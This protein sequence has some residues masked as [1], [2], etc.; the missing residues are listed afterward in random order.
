MARQPTI[1]KQLHKNVSLHE[2][3]RGIRHP[4]VE[5]WWAV[6]TTGIIDCISWQATKKPAKFGEQAFEWIFSSDADGLGSFETLCEL[7]NINPDDIRDKIITDPQAL[8]H[9]LVGKKK[10]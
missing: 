10:Q 8:K 4:E 3:V 2:T 5:L 6:L 1:L 9:A 7:F